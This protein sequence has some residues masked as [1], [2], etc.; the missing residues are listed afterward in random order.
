MR[1]RLRYERSR[2]RDEI[3]NEGR[4]PGWL[5]LTEKQR[6]EA[7]VEIYKR[8]QDK[9][10]KKAERVV[11]AMQARKQKEAEKEAKRAGAANSE[12]NSD[13]SA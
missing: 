13:V 9:A 2:A 12:T 6:A 3:A 10:Y 7:R 11:A 1:T 8:E 4:S 5:D